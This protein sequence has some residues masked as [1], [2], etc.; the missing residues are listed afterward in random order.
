[1]N[2]VDKVYSRVLTTKILE[3]MKYSSD[4][5]Y[6]DIMSPLVDVVFSQNEDNNR[7]TLDTINNFKNHFNVDHNF[8]VSKFLKKMEDNK[9]VDLAKDIL[10]SSL[11]TSAKGGITRADVIV[12]WAKILNKFSV[13]NV[14]DLISVYE[15]PNIER[16]LLT[17]NGQ[18]S[19]ETFRNFLRIA[20]S[21]DFVKPT[22]YMVDFVND[23]IDE[24]VDGVQVMSLLKATSR[25]LRKAYPKLKLKDLDYA[26]WYYMQTPPDP[27][28]PNEIRNMNRPPKAGK[29]TPIRDIVTK[30]RK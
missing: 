6:R 21:D 29:D 17:I 10:K 30:S 11:R 14:R 12:E 24:I 18:G 3:G 23:S 7:L 13:Q 22:R 28:M 25:K 1:M 20:G 4:Y 9:D 27:R 16:Q 15:N 26:I 19:G 5:K 8:T 2:R